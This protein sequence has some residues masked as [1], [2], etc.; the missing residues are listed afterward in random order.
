MV[1][2]N[3]KQ[4]EKTIS[5][6][7]RIALADSGRRFLYSPTE[8]IPVVEVKN[9]LLLGKLTALRFLEWVQNNPG[10]VIALPTGKTPEHFIKWVDYYLKNWNAIRVR[11]DLEI[12]IN[13]LVSTARVAKLLLDS[14]LR[15]WSNAVLLE[16]YEP[17][18]TELESQIDQLT[19]AARLR[20]E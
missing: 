7:E 13:L 10:G 5:R 2:S 11:D 16:E 8:K 4:F 14:N 1:V 20:D 19:P 9:F 17:V 12:T 6:V 3:R 15:I 18:R